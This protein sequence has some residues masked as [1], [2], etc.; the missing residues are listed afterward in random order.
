[1]RR[2]YGQFLGFIAGWLL[3]RHPV[4]GLLGLL[5]GYAFDHDW[6]TPPRRGEKRRPRQEQQAAS[7]GNADVDWAYR[8]FDLPE[9][10]SDAEIDRAYRRMMGQYHPDRVAGAAPDLQK[11]AETKSR[12]INAAYDRIQKLRKK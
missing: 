12:E 5:V 6:F 2:W 3:L 8:V 11:L 9:T 1:M 10:A 4:G 7:G